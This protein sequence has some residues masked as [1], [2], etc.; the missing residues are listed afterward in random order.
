M[1]SLIPRLREGHI[2]KGEAY[3]NRVWVRGEEW[4]LFPTA[5]FYPHEHP[6]QTAFE[7]AVSF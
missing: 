1:A 4:P 6:L 7:L 2:R 3:R 5:G